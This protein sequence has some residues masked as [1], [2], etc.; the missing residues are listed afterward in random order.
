MVG[1]IAT[2]AIPAIAGIAGPQAAP[3]SADGSLHGTVTGVFRERSGVLPH[4]LLAVETPAGRRWVQAGEDGRYFL[5]G[6]QSGVVTVRVAPSRLRGDRGRGH[7]R[8][9]R[10]GARRP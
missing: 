9:R 2:W 1:V 6:L 8:R 4:A 10:G 5:G 7:P 3:D